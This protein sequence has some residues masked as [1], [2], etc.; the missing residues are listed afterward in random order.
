MSFGLS[1]TGLSIKRLADIK[2]ELEEAFR[3]TFGQSINIDSR[4]PEGQLIGILSEREALV[5]ELLEQIYFSQYPDTSEGVPL[6][7]VAAIT[8]TVRK[9]PTKSTVTA[10]LIGTL[11]TL[12]PK[13]SVASVDGNSSARFVLDADVVIG[14][15][16]DEVQT[17]SFEVVPE[18]GSFALTL[19]IETTVTFDETAI[20]SDLETGLEALDGIDSVTVTGTY[21]AGFVITFDNASGKQPIAILVVASNTFISTEKGT[22]QTVADSSGS[23]HQTY[24]TAQEV[25]GS[26]G[27]W[28]DIDNV[29]A[30]VPAGALASTRQVAITTINTNDADTVVATKIA[31]AMLADAAFTSASAVGSLIS[32]TVSA[33]GDLPDMV[34]GDTTFIIAI[35]NQGRSA[36]NLVIGISE[37]TEGK[38]PQVDGTWTAEE[39]GVVQAVADTLTVI[40]TPVSGWTSISNDLDAE[41]G[42]AVEL[43]QAFKLRRAQEIAIAG[44]A[45][46]EAIR[47]ALLA[48]DNVT[49][50]VVFQNKN[51][52]DD[53]EGRP[54]HSLDIVVENGTDS[55]IGTEIFEVIGGGIETIGTLTENITD[56]QGFNQVIKFS[57]PTPVPI[58]IDITMTVD[59]NLFPADGEQQVEDLLLVFGDGLSI[60]DDVIVFIQLI[61]SF[62][63]VPG[64]LDV[65]VKIATAPIPVDGSAIVTAA[66]NAGDIEFTKTA[67]GLA[68][69]NKVTFSNSGGALPTGISAGVVYHL[70]SAAA[71]TFQVSTE[72]GGASISFTDAG[73]GTHTIAFGGRDDN[74]VIEP[75]EIADFDSTRITVTAS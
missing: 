64:I 43:D 38:F 2:T 67:H 24:F 58:Y 74:I 55:I 26:I 6:D 44:K 37:T 61:C 11:A 46:I 5:W 40:E 73:T 51:A 31:A 71:N 49:A 27:F 17:I 23:L 13:D 68:D 45:T 63:S 39:T 54:P 30:S 14:V 75:R 8:G 1:S 70:V 29:G 15:G 62:A 42:V 41:E 47:S 36:G 25:A 66:D 53:S 20:A 7:N 72:R 50:A 28:I 69:N 48:L 52:I 56:S 32:W 16:I 4:T 60:G 57:R 33:A 10:T 9:D 3:T 18:S 22:I 59:S 21:A 65:G 35:T 34:D 12:I 19:G